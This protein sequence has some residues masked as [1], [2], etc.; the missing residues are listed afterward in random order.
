MDFVAA[1][2]DDRDRT[3]EASIE[4]VFGVPPTRDGARLYMCQK[5]E[6]AIERRKRILS[7]G[8]LP[9][10][11]FE[12]VHAKQADHTKGMTRFLI[13]H[14]AVVGVIDH[15]HLWLASFQF[16]DERM[17][18]RPEVYAV[19]AMRHASHPRE[20]DWDQAEFWLEQQPFRAN[21]TPAEY[22]RTSPEQLLKQMSAISCRQMFE[23][24]LQPPASS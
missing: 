17:R 11:E 24:A 21:K 3:L 7:H 8:F 22:L 15:S 19:N 12:A 16:S 9:A 2:E 20:T 4:V 6:E 5:M 23:Q 13:D 1:N 18:P 14:S 10:R